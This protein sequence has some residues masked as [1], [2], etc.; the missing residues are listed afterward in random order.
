MIEKLVHRGFPFGAK[1]R[2]SAD[3]FAPGVRLRKMGIF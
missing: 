3:G 1:D 2:L